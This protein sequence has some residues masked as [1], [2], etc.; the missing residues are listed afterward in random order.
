L[1]VQSE[2]KK[3]EDHAF[4]SFRVSVPFGEFRG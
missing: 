4:S 2:K 3:L 1:K